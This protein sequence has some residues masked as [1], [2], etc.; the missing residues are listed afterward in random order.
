[1]NVTAQIINQGEIILRVQFK[2]RE[3][4]FDILDV[5][6]QIAKQ[7]SADEILFVLPDSN[8]EARMPVPTHPI[9]SIIFR[10]TN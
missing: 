5:S 1:M 4:V 3:N 6:M 9:Q 10:P 7:E 2:D 8:T